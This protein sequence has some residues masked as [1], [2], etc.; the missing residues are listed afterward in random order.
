MNS[1]HSTRFGDL[2]Y[3]EDR[4]ITL[5]EGLVGLPRLR[6]WIVL[7]MD[8]D[9]PL[10]WLQSLDDPAFGLPVLSPDFY[11]AEAI[12]E[13]VGDAAARL[14]VA[15]GEDLAILII[16]T[17]HAGGTR[18]T[19]N[20]AA[21]LVVHAGTRRGAQV[22]LDDRR[23]PLRQEIDYAR[24]GLAVQANAVAGLSQPAPAGADRER[25]EITL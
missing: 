1:F 21:P 3:R 20:L 4:V 15:G 13:E 19:G 9:L 23:W 7:D 14:G 6:R 8:R 10:K 12:V 11:A 5:D 17:V 24:F 22:V 16:T 18:L 25:Q 2:D